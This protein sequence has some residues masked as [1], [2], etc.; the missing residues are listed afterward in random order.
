MFQRHLTSAS[1][2]ASRKSKTKS[3]AGGIQN[4]KYKTQIQAAVIGP[5]VDL[6]GERLVRGF[7]HHGKRGGFSATNFGER[8]R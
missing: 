6:Y 3:T 7:A 5:A 8:Q 2:A 4:A 1:G